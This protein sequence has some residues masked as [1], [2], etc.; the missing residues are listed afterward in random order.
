MKGFNL[1][2]KLSVLLICLLMFA[3][4]VSVYAVGTINWTDEENKEGTYPE[5]HNHI[6]GDW[7]IDSEPTCKDKG[8]RTRECIYA[9]SKDGEI[10]KCDHSY[11]EEIPVDP[12]VHTYD[13]A[14]KVIK[15]PTCTS[16][17]ES[18]YTCTGCKKSVIVY[19]EKLPHTPDESLWVIHKPIHGEYLNDKSGSKTTRCTV[20]KTKIEEEIP[21]EHTFEGE[22]TVS[23][24]A[25]CVTKGKMLKYCT[26]CKKNIE[27]ATDFD[28]DN[29]VYSGKAMLIGS[30][31]CETPGKGIVRCEGCGKTAEVVIPAD[32]EHKYLQWGE[33]HAPEGDCQ[34]EDN[35][36]ITKECSACKEAGRN[37]IVDEIVWDGHVFDGSEGTHASTCSTPGYKKGDCIICGLT[38]VRT[39]LPIDPDA[40]SWYEEILIEPTCTTEGLAY[41]VCK[42]DTS[43]VEYG[44]VD[45][46]G[47]TFITPWTV[48]KVPTCSEEGKRSNFCV[49]CKNT[50]NEILPIDPEN[51]P[52]D[53]NWTIYEEAT[54]D[55]EGIEKA[56]CYMCSKDDYIERKIPKHTATLILKSRTNPTCCLNGQIVYDC[57]KCGEDVI[58]VIPKDPSVHKLSSEH[59]V[60]K[61]ATCYEEGLMS[62]ACVYCSEA[63]D[64][65]DSDKDKQYTIPKLD[66]T[67]TAWKIKEPATCTK[68][69]IKTRTCTVCGHI[70]TMETPAEH[71]YK[72]WIVDEGQD[73][74]CK[75]AGTRTR[76]CYNCDQTWT[77]YNYYADHKVEDKWRP[78]KDADCIKGG[79]FRKHCS[80]CDKAIVEKDVA[81][82]EHVDL[83]AGEI[84]RNVSDSICIEQRFK[85]SY[86]EKEVVKADQHVLFKV[87]DPLKQEVIPTCETGGQTA[88]YLC[89]I[90]TRYIDSRPLEPL[91]HEYEYNSNGT[92]YC[93]RCNYYYSQ[94]A[95][96]EIRACTHFCHNRGTFG[97]IL[98]KFLSFFWKLFGTNHFCECGATHYHED[99][100][101][102]KSEIFD[103]EGKLA[104]IEYACTGCKKKKAIFTF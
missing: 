21:V 13:G 10:L 29:H 75:K 3:L 27:V 69:G 16:V 103:E 35:G 14:E 82:G 85:C 32:K 93:T 60:E 62:K 59:R 26:V 37:E 34:T 22:G 52:D 49:T 7:V 100:V 47:H 64:V 2:K 18:E 24:K 92:K 97:K 77:E 5:T 25:T 98:T 19:V 66:H 63:I 94:S 70:E 74:S 65:P 30:I 68:K 57:I 88:A 45:P 12:E 83:V 81:K 38:G 72:S 101:T 73:I 48:T 1:S 53:L 104:S 4:T 67:V 36:Y 86:C 79:I 28:P 54:C 99:E 58:E 8:K 31:D 91:G 55:E 89:N 43:H 84:K 76:G 56:F 46:V 40:H 9:V 42:Y 80:V 39:Y 71:R 87:D 96:G 61:A 15:F 44:P 50:I 95:S 51:H 33:Y 6:Y 11:S 23:K 90:C 41:R 17:G 102:V 20:C 78:Y